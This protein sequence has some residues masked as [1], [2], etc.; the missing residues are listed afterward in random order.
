MLR[1]PGCGHSNTAQSKFCNQCG[2]A[3]AT[4]EGDSTKIIPA[5]TDEAFGELSSEDHQA[6]SELAPHT[7]LLLVRRGVGKGGKY[8]I[9]QPETIAGRHPDTDIFLNDITVSR[10]HARFRMENDQLG[11]E[12]L[13]STNGTYVN[14]KLVEDFQYLAQGDEVQIG[15]Y[16]MVVYTGGMG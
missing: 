10:H 6:I 13:G 3:L 5:L 9:N 16:R 8:L 7:A 14:R 11:V 1:C 2:T 4:T 15:K 12:D